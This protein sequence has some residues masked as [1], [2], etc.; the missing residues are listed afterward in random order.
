M[1]R[2]TSRAYITSHI[3]LRNEV[4]GD[5]P[6][7]FRFLYIGPDAVKKHLS[8]MWN[9]ITEKD[10]TNGLPINDMDRHIDENSFEVTQHMVDNIS[11]FFI[12]FPDPTTIQAQAKCVAIAFTPNAPRYFTMEIASHYINN[13]TYF[14][15]GE[16]KII[17]GYFKHM[18]YGALS[19]NTVDC[20]VKTVINLINKEYHNSNNK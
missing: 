16:W 9:S 11:I 7:L 20:F 6:T 1:E 12:T 2:S 17:D 8:D 14:V 13:E 10:I 4:F 19:N 5:L 18:N 3:K 15:F